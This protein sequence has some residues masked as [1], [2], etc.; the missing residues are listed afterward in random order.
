MEEYSSPTLKDKNMKLKESEIPAKGEMI[1]YRT[2]DKRIA[3]VGSGRNGAK[4]GGG[5][6]GR[7]FVGFMFYPLLF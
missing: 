5:G 6:S 4:L 3:L 2:K 7:G 1:F